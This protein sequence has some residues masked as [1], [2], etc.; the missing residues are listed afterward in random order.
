MP[1]NREIMR[2]FKDLEFVEQLGSGIPK[3]V[4]KYGRGVISVSENV[5]QTTLKFDKK[6]SGTTPKPSSKTTQKILEAITQNPLVSRQELAIIVERTPDAVKQQLEK[7]KAANQI[8]RVGPAK[9][10]HWEIIN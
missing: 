8:R 5:V 1:R 6:I 10:G 3:I 4:H 2:V 7:L 9:G